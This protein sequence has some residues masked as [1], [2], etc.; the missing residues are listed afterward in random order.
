MS[1]GLVGFDESSIPLK[2][3]LPIHRVAKPFHGF[4]SENG[5]RCKR[6]YVLTHEKERAH[7]GIATGDEL[8]GGGQLVR[9]M[10]PQ[11]RPTSSLLLSP[12]A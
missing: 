5:D 8:G 4:L 6:Y 11:G 12:F 2:Q 1:I 7:T 3:S 10:H 9:T